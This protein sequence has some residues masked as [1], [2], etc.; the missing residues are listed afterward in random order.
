M[1]SQDL[2]NI[3][4]TAPVLTEIEDS[5]QREQIED[6][7]KH[8]ALP[9]I[10]GLMLGSKQGQLA[11]LQHAPLGNMAEVSRAAVIQGTTKGIELFYH[12]LLELSVPS[13]ED[14]GQGD[15]S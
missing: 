13:I 1:I 8:P 9:L 4:D 7:L 11:L 5:K 3:L 15:N 14:Q 2:K 10:W 12:T 6:L